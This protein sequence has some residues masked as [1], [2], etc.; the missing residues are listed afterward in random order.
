MIRRS[1]RALIAC[2]LMASLVVPTLPTM[3]C[4]PDFSP[5]VFTNSEHPD[6]PPEAYAAGMLGAV[7]PTYSTPYLV[8]AYRYFSGNPLSLAEQRQFVALWKHYRENDDNVGPSPSASESE[9]L[10][11]LRSWRETAGVKPP[12][13]EKP[14]NPM[15][16]FARFYQ[17]YDN[18][19][20]DAYHTASETLVSRAKQFGAKDPAMASWVDAQLAVFRNCNIGGP[21]RSMALPAAADAALPPV[22]RAD[23]DYQIAAAYF[24]ADR[25]D[26]AEQRFSVI[27]ADSTSPWR[28][29]A[30]LVAARCEIRKATLGTDDPADQKQALAAAEAQLK[31]IGSDDTLSSV[32]P[33]AQRLL[34][35][36]EFRLHPGGRLIDLSDSLERSASPDTLAQDLD[37]YS[38]L[39][40][41]SPM[42]DWILSF[43]SSGDGPAEAHRVARWRDTHSL[44]WLVAAL[45][46]AH[47]D[48]PQLAA[49]LTASTKVS[50]AS[51]AYLS[52]AF[53]R[54]RVLAI[55]GKE[56][57]ARQDL[58]KILSIPAKHM[59][60]S[61]RNLF[62]SL[63]MKV[64]RNL[65]EFLRYAPRVPAEAPENWLDTGALKKAIAQPMFDADS[66]I[67]FAKKMPLSALAVSA[68]SSTLPPH[69]RADVAIA[70]WTR[71]ILVR[72]DAVAKS[73]APDVVTLNP[74]L[75]DQF[76]PYVAAQDPADRGFA[77]LF[78]LLHTPGVRPYVDDGFRRWNF[79]GNENPTAIDSY[80]D[81]WWCFT[82][83]AVGDGDTIGRLFDPQLTDSLLRVY[84]NGNVLEPEFL[85]A[86]EGATL[87]AELVKL[88]A[89]QP[90]PVWLARQTLTWAKTHPDDP[91]IPEALHFAVRVTRYGCYRADV[92]P[93]SHEAFTLLHRRYP[94]SEWT[95]RTP[96]WFN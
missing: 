72:D 35:F 54:D 63:R 65:E 11:A 59:P 25:W 60:A 82:N 68:Q 95:A 56:E 32:K 28:A 92:T 14:P 2:G 10:A 12:E 42:T 21:E 7:P 33:S 30:S 23:R 47:P 76:T 31:T 18:C 70:A 94:K 5:P 67:F 20:G 73:L 86:S 34:G 8:I 43:S 74:E 3:A 51:S 79:V 22:I 88:S 29:T 50:L 55:E 15:A 9:W 48:T 1:Y 75:K 83:G 81:N 96:Y 89:L 77:A 38:Q 41:K 17:S 40:E 66:A 45:E 78:I 62:L 53:D 6:L 57:E 87:K 37:D 16:M 39:V 85:N 84:P 49:L 46:D 4:G 13:S 26:E 61:S 64:A 19:L 27:S 90:G 44:A 91:R 69:L 24:Y 93:Y 71:A 58:D 80:R 52:L 36:V